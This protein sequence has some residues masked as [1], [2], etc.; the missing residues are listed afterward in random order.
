VNIEK[1]AGH[2]FWDI[3]PF[4]LSKVL[5]WSCFVWFLFLIGQLFWWLSSVSINSEYLLTSVERQK[6]WDNIPKM[7]SK[8][9]IPQFIN[10]CTTDIV[11]I[12]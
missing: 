11:R 4:F 12:L 8:H 7:M 1:K 9:V 5:A 10:K 3:I 6:K 2:H